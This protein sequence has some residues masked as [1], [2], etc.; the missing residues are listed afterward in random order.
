MDLKSAPLVIQPVA[1]RY[2]VYATA[3]HFVERTIHKSVKYELDERA[4]SVFLNI[5]NSNI[6]EYCM[7][8][9]IFLQTARLSR[10]TAIC[11]KLVS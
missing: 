1:S 7:Y 8:G 3:A 9:N 11:F 10:Q 5:M 4:K 2:T 6:N